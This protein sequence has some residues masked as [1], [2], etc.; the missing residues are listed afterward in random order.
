M[1]CKFIHPQIGEAL[2]FLT[3]AATDDPQERH[4]L[5]SLYSQLWGGQEIDKEI[6]KALDLTWNKL[7]SLPLSL[8]E[9]LMCDFRYRWDYLTKTQSDRLG[10]GATTVSA[11]I[12]HTDFSCPYKLGDT[13][14]NH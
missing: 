10:G 5:S 8:S 14:Q 11:H 4:C 1:V 12:M 7:E 2:P 3:F 13:Y 6:Q 9:P